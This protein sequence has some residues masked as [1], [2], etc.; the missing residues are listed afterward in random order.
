MTG[1]VLKTFSYRVKDATSGKRLTVL[2]NAVNTVWNYAN[3][4]SARSAERDKL[5]A[6]KKQLRDLTKGSGKLLGLWLHQRPKG[7]SGARGQAM[8][9]QRVRSGPRPRPKRCAEHR[10]SRVRDAVSVR[11]WKSRLLSRG[12]ITPFLI[13]DC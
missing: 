6:T 1:P 3:E 8:D 2:A 11:A 12:G 13:W 5:W 9:V 10:P 4:I 7:S